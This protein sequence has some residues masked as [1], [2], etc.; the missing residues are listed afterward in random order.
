MQFV[1]PVPYLSTNKTFLAGRGDGFGNDDRT[2]KIRYAE[3]KRNGVSTAGKIWSPQLNT[4]IDGK[5]DVKRI[6]QERNLD[7]DGVVTHKAVQLDPHEDNRY[8]VADDIVDAEVDRIAEER[9]RPI[10]GKELPS[11][12]E[13]TQERLSGKQD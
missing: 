8:Q 5:D 7:C 4:W 3:A 13:E 2:R 10:T 11:L 6:C 12:R 1:F 9:G